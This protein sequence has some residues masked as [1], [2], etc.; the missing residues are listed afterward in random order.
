[1]KLDPIYLSEE[2]S[3]EVLSAGGNFCTR[4]VS[5]STEFSQQNQEIWK[6]RI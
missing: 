2:A 1:M 3:I 5:R 6:S 4:I